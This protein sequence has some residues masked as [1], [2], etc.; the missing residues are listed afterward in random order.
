[1]NADNAPTFPTVFEPIVELHEVRAEYESGL[2][3]FQLRL[4]STVA[5]LLA[6][7]RGPNSQHLLCGNLD[8]LFKDFTATVFRKALSAAS[9]QPRPARPRVERTPSETP[10]QSVRATS[11]AST[12]AETVLRPILPSAA[13]GSSSNRSSSVSSSAWL[14]RATT[15][16]SHQSFSSDSSASRGSKPTLALPVHHR[17]VPAVGHPEIQCVDDTQFHPNS[18]RDSAIDVEGPYSVLFPLPEQIRDGDFENLVDF[19]LCD[20]NL[21]FGDVDACFDISHGESAV[22][23]E[24]PRST[25]LFRT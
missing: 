6:S 1:M 10:S 24:E 8:N 14:S 9:T 17:H 21:N 25:N 19:G 12:A 20:E 3:D 15:R 7:N 13:G 23:D 18:H 5:T 11:F 22:V 2:A 16:Q 4:E